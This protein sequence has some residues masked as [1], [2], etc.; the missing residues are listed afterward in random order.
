MRINWHASGIEMGMR[1]FLIQTIPMVYV[2]DVEYE[3]PLLIV[4]AVLMACL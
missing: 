2:Y 4:K 1:G 3:K